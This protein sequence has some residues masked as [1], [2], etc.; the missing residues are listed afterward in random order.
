MQKPDIIGGVAMAGGYIFRWRFY[1]V[2]FT[3]HP[4]APGIGMV[5]KWPGG[6]DEFQRTRAWTL[7]A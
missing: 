4:F 3:F 2:K 7:L 5:C 1:G 6:G